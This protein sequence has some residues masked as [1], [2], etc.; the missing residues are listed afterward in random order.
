[1]RA[2]IVSCG[3]GAAVSL[4]LDRLSKSS[5]IWILVDILHVWGKTRAELFASKLVFA[6]LLNDRG[7]VIV[8]KS[9]QDARQGRKAIDRGLLPVENPNFVPS[10]IGES[11]QSLLER[12]HRFAVTAPPQRP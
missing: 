9:I 6:P 8:F 11:R 7:E 3:G 1:M 4:V 5:R 12:I 2:P 10:F